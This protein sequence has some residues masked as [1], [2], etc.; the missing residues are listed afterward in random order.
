M[1]LE[2]SVESFVQEKKSPS[3]AG[4]RGIE[5]ENIQ[6]LVSEILFQY[7]TGYRI[8][9][10]VSKDGDA[11]VFNHLVDGSRNGLVGR[12]DTGSYGTVVG[13]DDE[14]NLLACIG[15]GQAFNTVLES[16]GVDI[17]IFKVF[18]TLHDGGSCFI[19]LF[20]IDFL[21]VGSADCCGILIDIAIQGE[22]VYLLAGRSI[23]GVLGAIAHLGSGVVFAVDLD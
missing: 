20:A 10:V 3:I 7:G 1:L 11:S 4:M 22:S 5:L 9:G 14:A 6:Y 17:R 16:I 21:P 8:F 13:F 2:S 15:E 12:G 23:E 18:V 19:V